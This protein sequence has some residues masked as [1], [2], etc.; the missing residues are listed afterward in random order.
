MVF[1]CADGFEV[2]FY[3][4]AALFLDMI[5]HLRN[6]ILNNIVKCRKFSGTATADTTGC[7]G[8]HISDNIEKSG[9]FSFN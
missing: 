4:P 8:R 3:M 5:K 1:N 7:E 9:I 6:P 2:F